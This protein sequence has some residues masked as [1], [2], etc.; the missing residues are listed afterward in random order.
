M[1]YAGFLSL[2][3][4][5]GGCAAP[6]KVMINQQGMQVRCGSYGLGVIGTTVAVA[7]YAE[8]V[9]QR[10]ALGFVDLEEFE[11]TEPAKVEQRPGVVPMKVGRPLWETGYVWTYQLS[12]S[13]TGTRREEV[14]GKELVRGLAAYVI[15]LGE[16]KLLVS[17]ELNLIQVQDKGIVTATYMPPSQNYDWPLELRKTWESKGE[18]E[19]RT[20]KLNTS[21]NREV[22]GYGIVRVPAGEFEAFYILST[23]DFGMRISEVWYSPQVRRHVKRVSYLNEG[24]L[25][26]ELVSY[27]LTPSGSTPT[28]GP[29]QPGA[30]L[31]NR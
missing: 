17:E 6:S 8:C 16:N 14:T 3:I 2:L 12:G 23:S 26:E 30:D 24:R 22:K 31:R 5:L 18:L 13:R 11:K 29:S 27:S 28:V 20:G 4:F 25:I 19:T 10:R 21:T 1:R 7:S 15:K 9:S